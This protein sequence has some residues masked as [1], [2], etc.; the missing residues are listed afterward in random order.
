MVQRR[1]ALGLRDVRLELLV[2][3]A[4]PLGVALLDLPAAVRVAD[5]A[6]ESGGGKHL[7]VLR[8]GRADDAMLDVVE[9]RPAGFQRLER[10]FDGEVLE[11]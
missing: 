1:A 10:V 5:P 8:A 7:D 11:Q 4:E 3:V 9:D 6:R 2:L